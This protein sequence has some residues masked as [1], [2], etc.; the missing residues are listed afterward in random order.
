MGHPAGDG[1]R[2]N[3]YHAPMSS[4]SKGEYVSRAGVKLAAALDTFKFDV[5]GLVCADLGSHVG[6]FVDCLLRRGA[7]KV[8]AVDTSYGTFAWKLR[9]DDRV[10]VMERTNAMHVQLP[11]LVDLVTI[12]LGWTKQAKAL[13]NTAK[14]LVPAGVV[15][16]LIKP[17]YE[18]AKELLCNGVLPDEQVAPVV[19][20]LLADMRQTGWTVKGTTDSPIRGRA[21]NREVFAM[22]KRSAPP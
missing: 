14:L 1:R 9:K 13:P 10:V 19:E 5:T 16:S 20:T 3:D 8:Y 18:A 7:A 17:H 12:D 15:L 2:P 6:G 4:E 22:L 21:G 11:E